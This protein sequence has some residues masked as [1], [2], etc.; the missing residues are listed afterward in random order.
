MK[1]LTIKQK[2]K[3]A[4]RELK[5]IIKDELTPMLLNDLKKN[6]NSIYLDDTWLLQND[7]KLVYF[8]LDDFCIKKHFKPVNNKV[9]V[10]FVKF[11]VKNNYKNI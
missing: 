3:E 1:K 4:I 10:E 2:E 6:L 9:N 8:T 11:R 5:K 7:N